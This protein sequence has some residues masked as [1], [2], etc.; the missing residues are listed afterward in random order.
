MSTSKAF[1]A[2]HHSDAPLL[3]GNV[4]DARTTQLAQQAGFAAVGTSSHAI[5]I[6]LGYKDGEEI[7]VDTLL[8]M[9]K[10][11]MKVA[12][13]PVSVDFESGYSN[14]PPEVWDNVQKLVDM[15]VAGINLEDGQVQDG[16]RVLGDDNEMAKKIRA[17]R[18]SSD[19]FINARVDTFTT[20]HPDALNE[21]IRRA[22]IYQEAGADGIFV[23]LIEKEEDIKEFVSKVDLPLNVF[24]TPNLPA[25]DALAQLGV[26]RISHGGKQ[27]DQLMKKSETIYNDFQK[28]KDYK[29]VL[30][31]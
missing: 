1:K 11:I 20:K 31:S 17:I 5:A 7:S 10:H 2:L 15:G 24:T 21:S 18:G 12:T 9:I 6:A 4:W 26:K 8:F 3:L 13:I 23:P 28:T 30:G 29:L 14:H 25:Y 27:Y 22:L 19:I 16:K